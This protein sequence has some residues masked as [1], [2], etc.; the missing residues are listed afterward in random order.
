MKD[1]RGHGSD[2]RGAHSAGVQQVGRPLSPRVAQ[3]IASNPQGFSVSPKGDIPT[4]GYMLSLPG[5]SEVLN[6]ASP[7]DIAG[8]VDRH[9]DA[10]RS[11]AA[12]IGGWRDDDSGKFY[13]DVSENFKNKNAVVNAAQARNQIA[14][15]E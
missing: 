14:V 5:H 3:V 8:F 9:A 2:P 13:L 6:S 1:A 15:W 7:K 11:P 4:G 12:H 10:F